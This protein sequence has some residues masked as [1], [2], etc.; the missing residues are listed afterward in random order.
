[1]ADSKS[2]SGYD[3][4]NSVKVPPLYSYVSGIHTT[5]ST[6]ND[7]EYD[8]DYDKYTG[9]MILY[10]APLYANQ[11]FNER[12]FDIRKFLEQ[13]TDELLVNN[14]IES[15][16]LDITDTQPYITLRILNNLNF[17]ERKYSKWVEFLYNNGDYTHY[18]DKPGSVIDKC[19]L[20]IKNIYERTSLTWTILTLGYAGYETK[21]IQIDLYLDQQYVL[22][23]F[24]K[25]HFVVLYEKLKNTHYYE[26][27]DIIKN[28]IKTNINRFNN[29]ITS[30]MIVCINKSDIP[31]N[32]LCIYNYLN[33]NNYID[34]II[35]G[36][37]YHVVANKDGLN[38]TRTSN[39]WFY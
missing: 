28:V 33:K 19:R 6:K 22:N 27:Q 3:S 34:C 36:Y 2:M 20:V 9:S 21:C 16:E 32:Y 29:Y 24:V 18:I 14:E 31:Y 37:R 38:V 35:D 12:E 30:G 11:S 17:C 13:L 1:M 39:G 15:Y 26:V 4:V 25:N 7:E 23:S 5:K 10:N 8:E